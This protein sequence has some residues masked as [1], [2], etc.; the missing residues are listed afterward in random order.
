M[1]FQMKD[2]VQIAGAPNGMSL[3]SYR[4]ADA[5]QDLDTAGYFNGARA[6]LKVGDVIFVMSN[7][8]GPTIGFG[9]NAVRVNDGTTVDVGDRANLTTNAD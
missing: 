7:I 8:G 5:F 3:W 6:L 1:A 4:T 9:I 2:L